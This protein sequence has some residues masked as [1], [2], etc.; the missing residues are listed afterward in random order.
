M[1]VSPLSHPRLGPGRRSQGGHWSSELE[2]EL[3]SGAVA[4]G[5]QV[6]AAATSHC[7]QE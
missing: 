5:R 6:S 1:G 3:D 7:Q 4:L 2:Q